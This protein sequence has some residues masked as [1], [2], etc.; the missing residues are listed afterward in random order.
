MNKLDEILSIIMVFVTACFFSV[1]SGFGAITTILVIALSFLVYEIVINAAKSNPSI[2][3]VVNVT[4]GFIFGLSLTLILGFDSGILSGLIILLCMGY[5]YFCAEAGRNVGSLSRNIIIIS[6]NGLLYSA[7]FTMLLFIIFKESSLLFILIYIV[8][9]AFFFCS[10][11]VSKRAG[12][13]NNRSK[14]K[15]EQSLKN[16]WGSFLDKIKNYGNVLK[17]QFGN[18]AED[19]AIF[20]DDCIDVIKRK[21][22]KGTSDN[23]SSKE[24]RNIRN[25]IFLYKK[26]LRE[27]ENT[28]ELNDNEVEML[29]D[30]EDNL[31]DIERDF[32][33]KGS[34][35]YIEY[36]ARLAEVNNYIE[37]LKNSVRVRRARDKEDENLK[38]ESEERVRQQEYR[39]K[40]EK[41][42]FKA[43]QEEERR[44]REEK[45]R[46][47]KRRNERNSSY[48]TYSGDS[49]SDEEHTD[50]KYKRNST[51]SDNAHSFD[52]D[53]RNS[54]SEEKQSDKRDTKTSGADTKYF[55]GCETVDDLSLRYKKLCLIYHP[56]SGNGDTDTYIEIKEEYERLKK[57]LSV[58]V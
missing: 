15:N 9:F 31:L 29:E 45:R 57:R 44:R 52:E 34:I 21:V 49:A 35:S 43:Q 54:G 22:S 28:H 27:Y 10:Y 7:M 2:R 51:Q 17:K 13:K 48:H 33:T 56:D 25:M 38:R 16:D 24:Y 50:N 14:S 18:D 37:M 40:K 19:T 12:A 4:I 41:E 47:N 20:F 6:V 46:Q 23:V 39:R 8:S 5:K 1:S 11:Y 26:E 42:A 53:N 58:T 32:K 30:I 36:E 3:T 55:K